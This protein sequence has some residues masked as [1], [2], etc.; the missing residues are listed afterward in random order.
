MFFSKPSKSFNEKT[1][2]KYLLDKRK[3]TF[4][5]PIPISP[6]VVLWDSY[7]TCN[8]NR[9]VNLIL[10][11]WAKSKFSLCQQRYYN[12]LTTKQYKKIQ[13]FEVFSFFEDAPLLSIYFF[14]IPSLDDMFLGSFTLSNL[15]ILVEHLIR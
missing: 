9:D 13:T 4:P 3:D 2:S 14:Q 8:I 1:S 7:Y 5:F 12:L 6:L 11:M 10:K 15:I